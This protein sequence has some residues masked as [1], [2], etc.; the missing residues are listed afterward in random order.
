MIYVLVYIYYYKYYYNM[1][2]QAVK[3]TI[4]CKQILEEYF[5]NKKVLDVGSGDI[6]GNNRFLFENCEYIGNDVASGKNVTIVSRTKDLIFSDDTFDTIVS[7]ECFEH[8]PEYKESFLKIYQMLKP[9]GLF[10]F[11]CASTGRKEHGTR[12]TTT[13]DSYG[14]IA[15]IDDMQD[16]YKNLTEFDLNEVLNLKKYFS[17]YDTYY[18]SESNDLYFLGIKK[19]NKSIKL[20]EYIDKNVVKTT[21]NITQNNKSNSIVNMTNNRTYLNMLLNNIEKIDLKDKI[22]FKT[23]IV[24]TYY[25]SDP[26]NFNLYYFIKNGI[27]DDKNIQYII[28]IN[29]HK[30]EIENDGKIPNCHNLK[31]IHRDN[32]GYDFG[33]H[34]EALEYERKAGHT[35]DYY[36]F[37]NSGSFGPIIPHYLNGNSEVNWTDIF[38]NKIN[39]KVKL[40]GTTIVCLAGFDA[41]GYGPKIEG[42]FFM[43]DKIGLDLLL[44]EKTIFTNHSSK[45]LAV[46]NGEF[47]LSNCIIRNGYTIDCMIKEYQNIDWTDKKNWDKNNKQYPS[48]HNSFYGKSLNPYDQIFYKWYWHDQPLVCYD[49]IKE[50]FIKNTTDNIQ[51]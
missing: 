18:N 46:I 28:V 33:G 23:L 45:N 4:F 1:H 3:F 36:F 13:N 49:I 9:D 51:I 44:A 7:T 6:N 29:G 8:D 35:Y 27:I 12:R 38:I 48:R 30:C 50:I 24:Y 2:E 37:M 5:I 26:S 11:T 31:V 19:G 17:S 42:Y 34:A 43:T 16:Y 22:H 40:V 10:F 14:T 47:G 39:D 15:H 20:K 25:S 41:A 21:E 32:T